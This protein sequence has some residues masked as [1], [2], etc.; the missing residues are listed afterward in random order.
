MAFLIDTSINWDLYFF[1]EL[2]V[3]KLILEDL[4][5]HIVEKL[6]AVLSVPPLIEEW[7]TPGKGRLCRVLIRPTL[8]GPPDRGPPPS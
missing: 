6:I 8:S 5:S 2:A 4:Y 1:F 3:E 7:T